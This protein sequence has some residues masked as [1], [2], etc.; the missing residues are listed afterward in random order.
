[1][2]H[3]SSKPLLSKAAGRSTCL[4]S[5]KEKNMQKQKDFGIHNGSVIDRWMMTGRGTYSFANFSGIYGV[6]ECCFHY[7]LVYPHENLM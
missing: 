6:G 4:F 5:R 1:M 3:Q 2:F 7:P